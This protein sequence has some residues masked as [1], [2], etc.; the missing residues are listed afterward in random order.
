M[1]F[2]KLFKRGRKPN[3]PQAAE[4]EVDNLPAPSTEVPGEEA[5]VMSDLL[6]EQDTDLS[7]EDLPE[8]DFMSE[9]NFMSEIEGFPEKDEAP[10][11]EPAPLPPPVQ[12]LPAIDMDA[13]IEQML[14][15]N[16]EADRMFN[17]RERNGLVRD[18]S[19]YDPEAEQEEDSY[20][21]GDGWETYSEGSI[22]DKEALE[23]SP[24]DK[25]STLRER[26]AHLSMLK[27][28]A[29]AA[30]V[31]IVI[32]GAGLAVVL[33]AR[34][35]YTRQET[36]TAISQYV[37]IE[38]PVDVA[39]NTNY[40]FVNDTASLGGQSLTV[41]RISAGRTATCFYFNESFNPD[42]YEIM[43]YDQNNKLFH[44]YQHDYPYDPV[45]NTILKF[46]GLS[47]NTIF[48]T[49]SLKNIE[50]EESVSYYYRFQKALTF[51]AP[52]YMNETIPL[53]E[54][55]GG[56]NLSIEKAV[57][58]NTGTEI[59]Y[60]M[61]WE[62][63]TGEI[64]FGGAGNKPVIEVR[65][66]IDVLTSYTKQPAEF[67][68]ETSNTILGQFT[69][70]PVKSLNARVEVVFK[71]LYY[72]YKIPP[73]DINIR[74]L[75]ERGEDN[76]Q[77]LYAGGRRLVLEGMDTQGDYVVL[78]LHGE[79]LSGERLETRVEAELRVDTED[80]EIVIPGECFSVTEGSDLL[81]DI[82]KERTRLHGLPISRYKLDISTVQYSVPKISIPLD[83]KTYQS[84]AQ[85]TSPAA[86]VEDAFLTRLAYK[87]QTVIHEK[88]T[89]FSEALLGN[90]ALMR[91]YTPVTAA[92]PPRY[93]VKVINGF[94]TEPET[95][96]A[97]V[98]EE[99]YVG[100]G[101]ELTGFRRTH[102]IT[103]EKQN[104]HWIIVDDKIVG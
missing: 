31:F 97:V 62:L 46:D 51:A 38:Q 48:I 64:R 15:M 80:G 82:S 39:N 54:N 26:I 67:R 94:F 71:D 92:E 17:P 78:T 58:S 70:A 89:G 12:D 65:E 88:I 20:G 77:T 47:N 104:N 34:A 63:G 33:V 60:S 4:S 72:F 30:V 36:K 45:K 41:R 25:K 50:T 28:A 27:V 44:R 40:I 68:F 16:D 84:N 52:V 3:A 96:L 57:F 8:M 98:E 59:F 22:S 32:V 95:Y 66:G 6:P 11:P 9:L 103:A 74:K 99:W 14:A 102:Q 56:L 13:Q 79:T 86:S 75:F 23:S 100:S 1:I 55:D 73:I 90:R 93:A 43:L 29:I 24:D 87:S 19:V 49:L 81:F 85:P 69:F 83:L 35:K 2:D 42:E 53:T 5:D 7:L 61:H 18:F 91:H 37:P 101:D 21:A 10:D 76:T